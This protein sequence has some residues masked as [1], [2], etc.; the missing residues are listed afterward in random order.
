MTYQDVESI[1]NIGVGIVCL[2]IYLF[3]LVM[4]IHNIC[5]YLYPMRINKPLILLFYIFVIVK[6]TAMISSLIYVALQPV[7]E[8]YNPIWFM[9]LVNF[10]AEDIIGSVILMQWLHLAFSIQLLFGKITEKQSKLRKIVMFILLFI[11]SIFSS[12]CA[13]F[14]IFLI[15]LSIAWMMLFLLSGFFLRQKMKLLD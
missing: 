7:Y 2:I 1:E 4:T 5:R 15:P 6:A 9:Y 11:W 10:F 14:E 3:T 8:K 12:T 13:A